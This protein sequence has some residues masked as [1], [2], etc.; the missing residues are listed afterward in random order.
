MIPGQWTWRQGAEAARAVRR[1][2]RGFTIVEL[3]IV[4][5]IMAI[6]IAIALPSGIAMRRQNRRAACAANLK[7]L[8]QALLLFRE[9]YGCFPPDRDEYLWTVEAHDAYVEQYGVEPPNYDPTSLTAAAYDPYGNP[10]VT[11]VTDPKT[12]LRYRLHGLGLY[13]LYYLGSYSSVLPPPDSDPRFDPDYLVAAKVVEN[14]N[15]ALAIK[16]FNDPKLD[17]FRGAGYITERNTFHCPEN[18]DT[19][20]DRA[21]LA[22]RWRLPLLTTP[23]RVSKWNEATQQWETVEQD[24]PWNNYD[25]FYHRNQW[26]PG[27]KPEAKPEPLQGAR[28]LLQPYPPADTVVTWCPYHRKDTRRRA[29]GGPRGPMRSGPGQSNRS[30]P[31]GNRPQGP[32][33][34][35]ARDFNRVSPGDQDLVLFADGSVRRLTSRADNRM[36]EAPPGD[37]GWP[38]GPVM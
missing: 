3:L 18:T 14:R 26:H 9:D 38:Q 13:T 16:G 30:G 2:G 31:G 24:L 5:G 34:T 32:T 11:A 27:Y 33:A 35:E 20:L 25:L 1:A 10:I 23:T 29:R 7:A 28:H 15:Q 37:T 6:L 21:A 12:G 17:W 4:I 22:E 19:D 8:G 36:F